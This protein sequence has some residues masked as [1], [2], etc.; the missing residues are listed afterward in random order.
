MPTAE[1]GEESGRKGSRSAGE[2]ELELEGMVSYKPR[3][4]PGEG[5]AEEE[6][7]NI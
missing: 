3:G 5:V 6:V 2:R 7:T 4:G 1:R